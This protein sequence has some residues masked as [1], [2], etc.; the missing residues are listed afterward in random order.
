MKNTDN[1]SFVNY[2]STITERE[3]D[4]VV[5][6]CW[7]PGYYDTDNSFFDRI[8]TQINKMYV[9]WIARIEVGGRWC[10]NDSQIYSIGKNVW[11]GYKKATRRYDV[12]REYSGFDNT[13]E[14][15]LNSEFAWRVKTITTDPA[16]AI[17]SWDNMYEKFVNDLN[18]KHVRKCVDSGFENFLYSSLYYLSCFSSDGP[19]FHDPLRI[20]TYLKDAL[21]S[22]LECMAEL[23][24]RY[25]ALPNLTAQKL[26]A[27]HSPLK[28]KGRI[29]KF[30]QIVSREDMETILQARFKQYLSTE[31]Y[32][33]NDI[34][35][36]G[37]LENLLSWAYSIP[38]Y[39][40]LLPFIASHVFARFYEAS[41]V[42]DP[43]METLV[44]CSATF[45]TYLRL[46]DRHQKSRIYL[47]DDRP[48]YDNPNI[49]HP[50]I[51]FMDSMIHDMFSP[52]LYPHKWANASAS[53]YS[54]QIRVNWLAFYLE[55]NR[56]MFDPARL[57][58]VC[59]L[60]RWDVILK[61]FF[62]DL[63]INEQRLLRAAHIRQEDIIPQDEAEAILQDF[64]C[65]KEKLSDIE[66]AALAFILLKI[67]DWECDEPVFEFIEEEQAFHMFKKFAIR[68][69]EKYGCRT[70][71]QRRKKLGAIR[72]VAVKHFYKE[73]VKDMI[74][75]LESLV[76]NKTLQ[77]LADVIFPSNS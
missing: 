27:P 24:R 71:S 37:E 33:R 46:F 5:R 62:N 60:Q 10:G 4:A 75:F 36:M 61:M 70:S 26:E 15:L 41:Q 50:V 18:D 35:I 63:D 7:S 20:Y 2:L 6:W 38:D 11:D 28:I 43:K 58:T 72:Y 77:N 23:K 64:E 39:N 53:D 22:T 67:P 31:F 13:V 69:F 16:L 65:F 47:E 76:D 51:N 1:M 25:S 8:D 48:E 49:S 21:N 44:D 3:M 74:D 52:N 9:Q 32:E 56:Y 12:C 66:E 73:C 55:Q 17:H 45:P 68:Q 29:V 19:H 54:A 40:Y 42:T 14:Q 30:L 34:Y 57:D 59:V